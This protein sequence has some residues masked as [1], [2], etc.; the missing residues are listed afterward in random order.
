[1]ILPDLPPNMD[2]EAQD[3]LAKLS[4]RLYCAWQC[5]SMGDH[6]FYGHDK[7]MGSVLYNIWQDLEDL[8]ELQHERNAHIQEEMKKFTQGFAYRPP[9]GQV[10]D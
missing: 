9:N 5:V 2:V 1:M 7:K 6:S 4:D 10:M 8:L 3:E